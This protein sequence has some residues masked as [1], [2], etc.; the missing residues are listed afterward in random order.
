[1]I[2]KMEFEMPFNQG[3]CLGGVVR[4]AT[5]YEPLP[6]LSSKKHGHSCRFPCV[7][8]ARGNTYAASSPKADA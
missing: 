5:G 2:G 8:M 6:E 4:Y 1:M 7:A 3:G